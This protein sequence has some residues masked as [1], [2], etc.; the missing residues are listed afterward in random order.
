M[1]RLTLVQA[2]LHWEN[3][4]ANRHYFAEKL[5][6][7]QG[8]SDLIVLPE[9]FTTGFSMNAASLAEGMDGETIEW[10]HQQAIATGAVIVGSIIIQE[11]GNFYNRLIWMQP[12]GSLKFYDKR[13][14]FTLA[15]E[16]ETYTA[17]QQKLVVE[18]KGWRIC[19]LICY[20]LRFP[21][22]SRNTEAYDIL[23]YIASWPDKRSQAWRSLLTARAIENQSYVIGVNRVGSDENGHY[24][25]GNSTAINFAGEELVHLA[26]IESSAT[27]VL[28]KHPMQQFREKLPFLADKDD[29]TFTVAHTSL[30]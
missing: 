3:K 24:Y 21:V 23:I 2:Q 16:H 1:L 12:D 19:P 14:L 13:H 9:M 20:D 17:G 26:H 18:Y 8:Q 7:L 11:N 30:R 28:D 15:K 6:P 22:W 27:I 10:M 4:I 25:V 5:K 29:F